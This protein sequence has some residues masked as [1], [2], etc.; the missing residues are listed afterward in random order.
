M[1]EF[2]DFDSLFATLELRISDSA[3]FVLAIEGHSTSGKTF[4]SKELAKRLAGIAVGTDSY[5]REGSDART[6]LE[7]LDLDRLGHDV[8]RLTRVG[9]VIIEGINLRDTLREL[10]IAPTAFIYL[11]VITVAGLWRDELENYLV[12]GKP[13]GNWTDRQSAHYHV[14]EKPYE[15]ADFVYV[16][17]ED[18]PSP[19]E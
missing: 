11:K 18:V 10:A 19:D 17:V 4:L 6:Y 2:T 5:A 15:R 1:Q 14:R 3:K 8:N 16:R 9:P 12:D 7:R 13:S